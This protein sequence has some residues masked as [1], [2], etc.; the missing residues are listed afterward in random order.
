MPSVV[1]SKE[2]QRDLRAI[3][4]YIRDALANPGAA[5]D[6]IT[7]LRDAVSSLQAMPE[8]GIPLDKVL[9][10]QTD[11][12]FLICK[13]YRVFYL[14]QGDVVEVVRILH[15]LQDYMRALFS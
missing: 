1:L 15:T 8:R 7:A 13:N 11:F 3:R 5:R 12:R 6:T 14:F 4:D 9:P 2:A 10:V